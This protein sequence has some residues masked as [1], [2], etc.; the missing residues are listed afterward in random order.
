MTSQDPHDPP[1]TLTDPSRRAG[2]GIGALVVAVVIIAA[3]AYAMNQNPSSWTATAPST[4]QSAPS[5][6]GQGGAAS[7]GAAR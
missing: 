5:T 6:T 3:I 7:P 2:W 1:R 4:T